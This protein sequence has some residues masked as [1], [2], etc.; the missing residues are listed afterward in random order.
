MTFSS[1]LC[2]LSWYVNVIKYLMYACVPTSYVYYI[3]GYD[4][5]V[6]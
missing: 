2:K 5:V 6:K 3:I 1:D 4:V